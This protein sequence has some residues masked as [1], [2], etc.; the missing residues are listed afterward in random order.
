MLTHSHMHKEKGNRSTLKLMR[1]NTSCFQ[2]VLS[3]PTISSSMVL[4]YRGVDN[5]HSPNVASLLFGTSIAFHS[6]WAHTNFPGETFLG[7]KI[8]GQQIFLYQTSVHQAT[9]T[10]TRDGPGNKAGTQAYCGPLF[11]IQLTLW[12]RISPL[13]PILSAQRCS[14]RMLHHSWCA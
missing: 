10:S 14:A 8:K 7:I 2:P 5:F 4:L 9:V 11:S 6:N 13:L 12:V 1:E 3:Q